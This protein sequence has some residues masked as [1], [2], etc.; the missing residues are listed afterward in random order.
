MNGILLINKPKDYTSHDI[1]AI[2]KKI[3][4][5]K[6]GHTGTLD[7]N[8]TGVLPLLIGKAT[9]ISKYLIN[10]DKIYIA[11]L[12]LG[13]K[14]DT[15]D[16]E[17]KVIE[18]KKVE[19]I[20][21]EK[22]KRELS[23]I[24]GKQEQTPPIYSAIKI[25]GKKLYE[26]ARSGKEVDI[27]KRSIEIYNTELIKIE[28][29]EITFKVSCSKGTYI[30]SL[31]EKIAEDLNTVGYMKELQRVQVGEFNIGQAVGIVEIRKNPTLIEDKIISIEK[32]FE[33]KRK[34]R[35]ITK[36]ITIIFKRSTI[37]QKI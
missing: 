26:Y 6:V 13:E 3:T 9:G 37:K 31:C 22:V 29:D 10:H 27:P 11:T 8:A 5:E 16:S 17:G 19:C 30:R 23:S 28:E 25:K 34:Y 32:Y 4:G 33:K 36:R 14:R 35:V 18:T 12:K 15:A 1:V 7:P 21:E 2:I 24:I 20:T